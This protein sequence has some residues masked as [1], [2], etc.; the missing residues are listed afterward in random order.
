MVKCMEL[1]KDLLVAGNGGSDFLSSVPLSPNGVLE[2][3][4]CLSF[5][6]ENVTTPP[7][8]GSCTNSPPNNIIIATISTTNAAAV[9]TNPEDKMEGRKD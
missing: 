3:A 1:I 2:A 5:K 8:V 9:S 7:V 6:S 4:A